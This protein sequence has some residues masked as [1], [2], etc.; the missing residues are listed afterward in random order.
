MGAAQDKRRAYWERVQK[1]R[2]SAESVIRNA[3]G[4]RVHVDSTT[5]HRETSGPATTCAT[6]ARNVKAV[7]TITQGKRTRFSPSTPE[8]VAAIQATRATSAAARTARIAEVR[9]KWDAQAE[10]WARHIEAHDAKKFTG[11]VA[12]GQ[13]DQS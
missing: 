4:E 9:G 5:T 11:F 13:P 12:E 10:A 2:R 1:H 6:Y 8:E 3:R 7:P